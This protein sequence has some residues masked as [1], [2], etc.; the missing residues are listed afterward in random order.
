MREHEDQDL[1]GLFGYLQAADRRKAPDFRI[2]MA[3]ARAE[4]ARSGQPH[5]LLQS[6][7]PR[8]TKGIPSRLA[9]GVSLLAAA[10]AAV[11][12]L[13]PPHGTSESEFV[14]VVQA[15]S[16]DPASG[17]WKSPTDALLKVPGSEALSTIPFINLPPSILDWG[18]DPRRNE[19]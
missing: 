12:L 6:P 1:E 7:G 14:H 3:R 13:L 17:A 8:R 11:L 4:A 5:D 16:R 2:I 9:W 18:V 15:F 19:L 10:A